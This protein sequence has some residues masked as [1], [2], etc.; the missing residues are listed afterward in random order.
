MAKKKKTL[1]DTITKNKE[2]FRFVFLFLFF[3]IL[4]YL[5]YYFSMPNLT[6]TKTT[7]AS[8]LGFLLSLI[9]VHA[10]VDGANILLDGLSLEIIDEC[11][12]IFSFIVYLACVIAYPSSL[13]DKEIGALIGIPALYS[14]NMLRLIIISLVEISYPD[15]FEI[16]HVYLWQ[17]TFIIFVIIVFLL[18]IRIV[19]DKDVKDVK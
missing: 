7:T 11:T 3:L 18:W 9:G 13:K 19:V 16:V 5:V 8:V 12:A 10:D 2:T 6:F 14:I 17:T 4:F 1:F 15:A